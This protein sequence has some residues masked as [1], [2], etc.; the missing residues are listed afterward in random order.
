MIMSDLNRFTGGDWKLT[1]YGYEKYS[2]NGENGEE[3]CFTHSQFN[4]LVLAQAKN[5]YEILNQINN[6]IADSK[7]EI[8]LADLVCGIA[9]DIDNLLNACKPPEK[10]ND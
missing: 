6:F 5:M 1:R 4:G 7:N 2:I 8:D 3:V 9:H 10:D